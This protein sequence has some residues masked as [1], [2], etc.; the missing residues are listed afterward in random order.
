MTGRGSRPI[1]R[2]GGFTR[3]AAS[4]AGQPPRPS[5]DCYRRYVL[6]LRRAARRITTTR[7][8]VVDRRTRAGGRRPAG[9]TSRCRRGERPP[10]AAAPGRVRGWGPATSP[11]HRAGAFAAVA[12]RRG[13]GRPGTARRASAAPATR[14]PRAPPPRGARR[15]PPLR[16]RRPARTP[17][18]ASAADA[19]SSVSSR[20]SSQTAIASAMTSRTA[21]ISADRLDLE[22]AVEVGVEIE[23]HFHGLD[24][25]GCRVAGNPATGTASGCQRTCCPQRAP[26]LVPR[27]YS[28]R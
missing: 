28:V 15:T 24:Y 4:G 26:S 23:G 20:R 6:S 2:T 5:P 27:P 10:V 8:S 12:P 7:R 19:R 3:V 13:T 16:F 1:G 25:A 18:S 21:Q 11:P 17:P 14:T 22:A 9:A